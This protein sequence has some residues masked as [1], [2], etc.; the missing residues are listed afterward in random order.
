MS[1]NQKDAG[2]TI[3]RIFE[4]LR[5]GCT[6]EHLRKFATVFAVSEGPKFIP[7]GEQKATM[8]QNIDIFVKHW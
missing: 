1:K 2:E 6:R 7:A 8:V 3:K 5:P 4:E